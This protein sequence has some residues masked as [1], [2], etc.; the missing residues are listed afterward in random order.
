MN[1]KS[2]IDTILSLTSCLFSFSPISPIWCRR[3]WPFDAGTGN[4][5]S[6]AVLKQFSFVFRLHCHLSL[7]QVL[8][9]LL[10]KSIYNCSELVPSP[11]PI[12]EKG[13][14]SNPWGGKGWKAGLW[15][16]HYCFV[17]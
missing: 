17:I 6:R 2:E 7:L 14:L 11:L 16:C 13:L 3:K 8:A 15:K 10:S 9:N 4:S 12:L 1:F 5:A